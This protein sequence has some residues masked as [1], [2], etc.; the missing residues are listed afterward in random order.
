MLI[1]YEKE[2]KINDWE[3]LSQ[4]NWAENVL[5]G[6]AGGGAQ[7]YELL[8]VFHFYHWAY[9]ITLFSE[10]TELAEIAHE[11]IFYLNGL[12]FLE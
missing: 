8:L 3:S 5:L 11:V 2:W 9:L 4:S 10:V 12:H 6:R 7:D 1:D